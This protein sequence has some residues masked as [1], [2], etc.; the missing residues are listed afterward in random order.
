MSATLEEHDAM[1]RLLE[2]MNGDTPS[3]PAA[4]PRAVDPNAP[5]ELAGPGQ[6]TTAEVNAMAD[7]LSK[8]NNV[9]QQV[10][11]E[12]DRNP[13]LRQ[14]VNTQRNDHGVKVGS[15][16]I[17][18]KEDEK[19]IAGK[20]Y[21]SIYHSQTND[22]IA[23]DITLYE[24]ALAVVKHLN[25]GKYANSHI[26]RKLFEADDAYTARR[27]DAIRFKSMMRRASNGR[28]MSKHD[29]YESRYQA[30]IDGA[31]AAKR[32]IKQLIESSRRGS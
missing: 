27:T 28:D 22:V 18:I 24:T 3:T 30:S 1:K 2:M 23:D 9:T 11:V 15:Y 13:Q 21:Y 8:L 12:S 14:A 20:Q 10:L 29:V 19:R 6:I 5:V 25:S 7:V 26:V 17:M 16:Q 31:M 4:K 32:E